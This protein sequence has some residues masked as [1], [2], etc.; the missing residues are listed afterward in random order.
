MNG[1][2]TNQ[3]N[4]RAV[5]TEEQ[6]REIFEFRK[7]HSFNS[8]HAASTFLSKKFKISSKAVRDIWSGRSWLDA[9]YDLW[10]SSERPKKKVVGRPKGKKDSKP[11]KS[12][13]IA[14]LKSPVPA[15]H[16]RFLKSA[17][18]YDFSHS[19]RSGCSSIFPTQLKET[20]IKDALQVKK[21][22]DIEIRNSEENRSNIKPLA[23]IMAAPPFLTTKLPSIQVVRSLCLRHEVT[24][25][26]SNPF[27]I[28]L[29][30]ENG[31]SIFKSGIINRLTPP[32]IVGSY[33]IAQAIFMKPG[34]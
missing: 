23:S 1:P 17:A 20:V 24:N 29:M 15:A 10:G 32:W 7:S 31:H 33:D 2:I 11:R 30:K 26:E 34:L 8:F 6:A 4:R 14:M 16:G 3:S 12:K 21:Q 18:E 28:D 22:N 25:V 27:S 19:T 5:L 13:S 9:T